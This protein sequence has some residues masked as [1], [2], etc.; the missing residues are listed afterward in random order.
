M[1][2]LTKHKCEGDEAKMAF[3][4]WVFLKTPSKHN[5]KAHR[6]CLSQCRKETP[7]ISRGG[8]NTI[9]VDETGPTPA[10]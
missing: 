5:Y 3:N 2:V 7:A 8:Q 6:E 10:L 9:A 1:A 4:N